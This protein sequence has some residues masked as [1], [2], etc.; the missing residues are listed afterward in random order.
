M[1]LY[2]MILRDTISEA[3]NTLKA[4]KSSIF[5]TVV[6][7]MQYWEAEIWITAEYMK[8]SF[9]S[10]LDRLQLTGQIF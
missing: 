6:F 5:V 4:L 1:L 10:S 3:R 2:F 8:T 9:A 7:D